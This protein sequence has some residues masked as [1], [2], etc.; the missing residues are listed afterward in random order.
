LLFDKNIPDQAYRTKER[1][2][3]R[4]CGIPIYFE[5]RYGKDGNIITKDGKTPNGIFGKENN[6]KWFWR[7]AWSKTEHLI[8]G[9]CKIQNMATEYKTMKSKYAGKCFSCNDKIAVG[10]QINYWPDRSKGN[11][12][13]HTNCT[14]VG[15]V[16]KVV[17]QAK[18]TSY[19]EVQWSNPSPEVL[20][21]LQHLIDQEEEFEATA[22]EITSDLHPNKSKQGDSFGMIVNAK[23]GHL[24]QIA[25]INAINNL[26]EQIA[27]LVEK[28]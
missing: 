13:Q 23:E 27:R 26:T 22:L 14:P 10:E 18:P 12:V 21:K 20:A 2:C 19:A 9:S 11:Q 28:K 16:D 4:G 25:K 24:I 3:P 17:D 15:T 7:E 1:P 6:V 5:A 8:E